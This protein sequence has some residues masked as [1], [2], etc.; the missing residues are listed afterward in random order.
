MSEPFFSVVIPTRNRAELLPF[1]IQ[2]VLEQTFDDFEI[3]VSNNF[4]TDNTRE[5]VAAFKDTRVRYFETSE[6]LDLG[7]SFEFA[8]SHATG[9]FITYLSDD[10]ACSIVSLE[11]IADAIKSHPNTKLAVWSYCDYLL[12]SINQYGYVAEPNNVWVPTFDGRVTLKTA[13]EAMQDRFAISGLIVKENHESDHR[14]FPSMINAA[15]HKSLLKAAEERGLNFFHSKNA[16]SVSCAVNDIYS[17]VIT[18]N[19]IEDFI[20]VDYPLHLHGAWGKS[21][22]TTIDGSR[23]F[24]KASKEEMLVPFKC[25]TNN[26]FSSNALLSAKRDVGSD[27]DY[28]EVD[29]AEF[30]RSVYTELAEMK[31]VG[32]DVGE[33]LDNFFA[34][35]GETPTEFQSEVRSKLPT[36]WQAS[37]NKLI[38]QAKS[39]LR[40]VYRA[41]GLSEIANNARKK[42]SRS[43]FLMKGGEDGFE[44][45]SEFARK[46][47][48]EWLKAHQTK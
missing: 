30:Y 1:A 5:V 14:K 16:G 17:L 27:L 3:I 28:I 10:D 25:Y 37:K 31:K 13:K 42:E 18:L 7:D 9:E 41:T 23:R 38:H 47:D 43:M 32:V 45:I 6:S 29:W 11:I 40:P 8:T 19:L 44:N 33:D 36:A 2:S 22:T 4:S 39:V 12:D 21:S 35:L 46:M 48:K 20:Y 15:L 24:Y 26:T 34:A